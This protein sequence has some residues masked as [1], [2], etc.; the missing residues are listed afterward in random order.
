MRHVG[1]NDAQVRCPNGRRV[2]QEEITRAEAHP[3]AGGR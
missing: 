3:F 1:E 2:Y